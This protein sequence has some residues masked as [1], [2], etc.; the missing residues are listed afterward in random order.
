MPTADQ[1]RA[2]LPLRRLGVSVIC[3]HLRERRLALRPRMRSRGIFFA[4]VLAVASGCFPEDSRLCEDA[5][6]HLEIPATLTS[7]SGSTLVKQ[8]RRCDFDTGATV[9]D[10][11]AERT[12]CAALH[13]GI[14]TTI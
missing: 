8:K 14:C 13:G 10:G 9:N 1:C 5:H 11:D 3:R 6:G 7:C 4:A 12:D 2:P